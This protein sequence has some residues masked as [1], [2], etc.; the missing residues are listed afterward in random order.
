MANKIIYGATGA[1]RYLANGHEVPNVTSISL[2]DV[3]FSTAEISGAGIMGTVN[4]P[5]PGQINAMTVTVSAR[6]TGNDKSAMMASKVSGE[7]RIAQNVRASDGTLYIAG[8][9]IYFL[10]SPTK[11]GGGNIEV[12]KTRDESVDYS[13]TRYREIVDGEETL[14][15]DQFAG[16][17]KVGNT[18]L[19]SGIRSVL[20]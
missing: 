11:I 18:D 8:T 5:T 14:L 9:R 19:M 3:E 1:F 13:V 16:K 4:M 15:V 12:N 10:G 7:I 2:P 20:E 6:A 17:F